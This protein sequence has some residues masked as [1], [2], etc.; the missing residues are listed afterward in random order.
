MNRNGRQS[1]HPTPPL[2]G[3]APQASAVVITNRDGRV[4]HWSNGAETLLGYAPTEIVG[5]SVT[6][7]LDTDGTPRHRDGHRVDARM[8]LCPLLDHE[9]ETAFLLT[10]HPGADET[11]DRSLASLA[12]LM[13][14]Q[15]PLGLAIFDRDAR[16]LSVNETGRQETDL[17]ADEFHGLRPAEINPDP[18]FEEIERRIRRAAETGKPEFTEAF[19]RAL[20]QGQAHAW[21]FD[22]F[23]L[24]D[25]TA[26]VRAVG[27][28]AT[29]YSE[30]YGSRERL[31]LVSEARTRIG[32]SLDIAETARELTEV[33]VPRFA[34]FVG[35][36]VL[37]PV[38][39]GELPVSGTSPRP[40]LLRLAAHRSVFTLAP[41]AMPAPGETHVHPSSSPIARCLA[42][43]RAELYD[44]RSPEMVRWLAEDPAHAALVDAYGAHSLIAVPIRARGAILGAVLFIRYATSREPFGLDDLTVTEDLVARVAICLDNDRRFTRER[45]IALALQRSL[46]PQ[47]PTLHPAVETAVRYL[48]AGGDTLSAGDWF[49]VI[50]LPGA[51]VGLVI[52]DVVGHGINASA[53]MGRLRTAVRTL[54]DI[55]LPPDELL[56]HLDDIVTHSGDEQDDAALGEIPGDIGATCLY[57][58]YDPVGGTCS[59]ARAGHPAPVLVHPDGTGSVVDLPAGPPL[60]LGSLPFEA[61]EFTVPEGSLLALF[62][63]GLLEPDADDVGSGLSRVCSAVAWP[64]PSLEALADTVL[65]LCTGSRTDDIALL[66]ARTQLLDR[67]HVASWDLPSDPAIVAKARER[68]GIQLAAWGLEEEV[69][70]TELVVSELVTNAIRYGR[71]PIQL[72]LI[73]EPSVLICEV[74]DCSSTSPR[75]RRARV[76]DEGGRGLLLVAQLTQRWGTRYT[77]T[78]KTIWAEQPISTRSE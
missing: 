10:I 68:V 34:D 38:F 75:L 60:G 33:A 49:D 11:V 5:R 43:G 73:H 15:H 9:R 52:G 45:G 44:L 59:L 25:E 30:Q 78:G 24:R 7:L 37:D 18:A 28:S 66:L 67:E 65:D 14:E 29:D 23:P 6:D 32:A 39:R 55:D 71:P 35:V 21:A 46:L 20:G 41:G 2:T 40:A 72:R 1:D 69:F 22:I 48:P 13:F 36:D 8:S 64:A 56:T 61:T 26:Q 47:G 17:A 42:K 27:V 76:S 31:A 16:A 51:R 74:S 19:V 63:D 77:G 50:P 3:I 12:Q 70:V 54:A 4:T 57:A 53:T 62:T 58:V